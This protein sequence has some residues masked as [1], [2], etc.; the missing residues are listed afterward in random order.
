MDKPDVHQRDLF[1]EETPAQRWEADG[2][3]RALDELFSSARKYRSADSFSALMQFIS[4]FRF[5]APYNAMLLHIQMPAATFV[6]PAD[7]W[8]REYGRLIKPDARPLVILQPRGPVMFVFDVSD[9]ESGLASC[10]LPAEV[11]KPFEG[12]SG[13]V[14]RELEC[15]IE[16]AKRDGIRITK[17]KEGSESAGSA[18]LVSRK[19]ITP[20]LFKTGRTK[21]GNDI[22]ASIA[23]LYDV[24]FNEDLGRAARYATIVHE[25]AHIYCGHLGAP[26]KKWWPDRRG[27][28]QDVAEFEAESITYLV[29]KRL[30][31]Q[32]PSEEYLA[33]YIDGMKSIPDISL[34]LIM[35]AGGLIE[36]MGQKRLKLREDKE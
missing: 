36:Q 6:A 25:L 7:R 28:V 32:N 24:L 26:N 17:R 2:I 34:E 30:G 11:E 20:L 3:K 4:R 5:Y 14:G 9:T 10:P 15:T 21:E 12:L 19:D 33:Q 16:N 35:K 8:I 29:C 31:I 13:Y 18:H 1:H 23:V 27:L 22:L